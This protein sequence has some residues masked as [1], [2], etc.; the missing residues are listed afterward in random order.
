M[1]M[2]WLALKVISGV[3]LT[4]CL[5][6]CAAAIVLPGL[7]DRI[8]VLV[9]VI[10]FSGICYFISSRLLDALTPAV[11]IRQPS[12]RGGPFVAPS[13]RVAQVVMCCVLT[14]VIV[15]ISVAVFRDPPSAV[16]KRVLAGFGVLLSLWVLSAAWAGFVH[17]VRVGH[18]MRIDDLGV[19]YPGT[20][21]V[22]WS[23]VRGLSIAED[24]EKSQSLVL[25]LG[26][27][28]VR[29]SVVARWVFPL[30]PGA[31]F[32]RDSVSFPLF[33]MRAPGPQVLAAARHFW[34]GHP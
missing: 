24:A 10:A 25:A 5:I 27:S 2:V 11:A 29:P 8:G 6:A 23:A 21:V 20:P 7:L 1:K 14:L 31:L 26:P 33:L 15:G 32:G 9:A 16:W 12:W 3:L 30:L 17:R 28:Y 18:A 13:R 4:L 22:P 34:A 19:H